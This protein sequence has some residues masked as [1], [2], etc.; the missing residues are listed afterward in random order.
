MSRATVNALCRTFPAP[1][2]RTPGAAARR[3]EG[4]RQDVRLHRLQLPGVAVKTDSV[5]TAAMLIEL[6]VG[7]RAPYF[8]RSWINIP[9]DMPEDE[10]RHRLAASYRIVRSGLTRKV[11]AGLAPFD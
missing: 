3:L 11:Q 1:S 10:L 5:E 2:N 9:W 6:G 8:H 7:R 4:G